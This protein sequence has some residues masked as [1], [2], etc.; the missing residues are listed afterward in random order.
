MIADGAP[1]A[2]K[3]ALAFAKLTFEQVSWDKDTLN[4][5]DQDPFKLY[6]FD[7]MWSNPT[8]IPRIIKGMTDRIPAFASR[9]GMELS[10]PFFYGVAK[11]CGY[12]AGFFEDYLPP[13]IIA[14]EKPFLSAI[15]EAYK[16]FGWGFGKKTEKQLE[17]LEAI[18]GKE[19][20]SLLA[21]FVLSVDW[22]YKE[23]AKVFEKTAIDDKLF[24][25]LAS[26]MADEDAGGDFLY[27]LGK[28]YDQKQMMYAC[29]RIVFAAQKL[30]NAVAEGKLVLPQEAFKM[31]T[32]F[33]QIS[34]DAGENDSLYEGTNWL[35]VVDLAG[36]D[37]YAGTCGAT[38]SAS[39]LASVV[40]DAKGADRYAPE[41]EPFPSTGAGVL[42]CGIVADLG[43]D[44]DTYAGFNNSQGAAL[45]GVGMMV[46]FGGNDTY[47]AVD[48]VQGAASFGVGV[49][50]DLGGNDSYTC[51]FGAQG[52]GFTQGFAL[53]FDKTGNDVYTADDT[54][55]IHPSAQN[56]S[57]NTS[58]AQ[59]CGNGRRADITD[60]HS[61]SG[62]CGMLVDGEGDDKYS[63]GVFG[64]GAG[65]WFGVGIL[66]DNAGNDEYSGLWYV[67]GATAHFAISVFRDEAGDDHYKALQATSL[68]VGHDFSISYH[69]DKGGNDRYDCF[70]L[71]KNDKA[72]E[73]KLYGGLMLGCGN[74][75]GMGLFFNIGGDDVYE[76]RA[77]NMYGGAYVSAPTVPDTIRNELLCLGVFLDV[78]GNDTYGMGFCKQNES[79][80]REAP[81]RPGVAVGIGLDTELGEVPFI[82]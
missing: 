68:G 80:V 27:R 42:G 4:R 64:Q 76:G 32:P 63:C 33:G 47:K 25:K 71:E 54:E 6:W 72:E 30:K 8:R 70:R 55:I 58:M 49:L 17:E 59:G 53:L 74:E 46:D 66:T 3:E 11:T 57:H 56:P 60:G 40:I 67:Q 65:Y 20:S 15:K 43:P 14:E 7:E 29:A 19:S 18:L 28:E 79:W 35:L 2:F 44:N 82:Y 52:Y 12:V 62:G 73:Q 10:M 41:L 13:L 36:N 5:L 23:R 50:S 22:A 26:L 45:M 69:I 31:L 34:L 39:N 75:T 61:M 81:N 37:T 51:F 1:D 48:F 77:D 24:W 78:G 38:S 9:E 21:N 16:N